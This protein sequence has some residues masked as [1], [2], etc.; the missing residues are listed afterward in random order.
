MERCRITGDLFFLMC[1]GEKVIID[2]I[3]YQKVQTK[4]NLFRP[5]I[6]HIIIT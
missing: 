3:C 2:I 5:A 6:L 4:L 1:V